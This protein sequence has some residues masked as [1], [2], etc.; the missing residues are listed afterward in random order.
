MRFSKMFIP[1]LREDP[2]EAEAISHKLLLRGGFI[3]RLA[4]GL[5]MYLPLGWRVMNKINQ[6]IREEM[7]AIGALEIN[8]P[9]LHP[10]EVWQQTGRW[11]DVGEEM[12]RLKDRTN[13]DL[14]LGMT[15][16]EIITFLVSKDVRSYRN[17]PLFLYQIQ[18]KFR[19][20]ARPRG[21]I[22]RT[23]E[24][25]MK[26]SYSFDKDE[27]GLSVSYDLH[28]E[29]Y[30]RI[31]NRCGLE[32][33]TAESDPGMMGGFTAHEFMSPTTEGE[34][35]IVL[36][37]ECG[38]VANVE[39]AAT[40]SPDVEASKWEFEEIF[41]KDNKTVDEVSNFLNLPPAYFIKSLLLIGEN[42]PFLA[43]IRGDQELHEKKLQRAIQGKFRPATKDEVLNILKVEAGNI[44]PMGHV[45]KRYADPSLQ[46]GSYVTGANK[47]NY[48]IRGVKANVHFDA[49]WHDIHI[50]KAG[51]R[52][53]KC[54]S[55]VRMQ[56]AVEIGNTFRLGTKYSSALRAVYLDDEGREKPII[57]GS[58]GIGPAR[59]AAA[60]V[61]Q[62]HDDKGI[63]WP[64]SIA[65]FDVI[66]L[67]LTKKDPALAK[68]AETL[69]KYLTKAGFEALIDDRD[70]RP[71]VKFNDADLIGI[72]WQVI[73]GTRSVTEGCVELKSR[74][75]GVI[76]KIK[77]E[78][79]VEKLSE[80]YDSPQIRGCV[81]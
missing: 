9:A 5:Y 58:Y 10:A 64:A 21:G 46:N 74:Q 28:L 2:S 37:D 49:E 6:I 29:A 44:G 40:F 50:S 14:C 26:D 25:I 54:D 57:M 69:T 71:G 45:L 16:E 72:P 53:S 27:E 67:P 8:L 43:L 22:I 13:R 17:L 24:F 23:R 3:R 41:T 12:F 51:D 62:N 66:L 56:H 63:I 11:S 7:N 4:T 48:H 18:T 52:C 79:V 55:S 60:A 32:F 15:H 76:E 20:E 61:Q 31:F 42:G 68:A 73:I 39:V 35:E 30:C 47:P 36:C 19:D 33:Y 70:E 80:K 38:Y 65:P 1:T 59:V 75:T 34:D 81:F 77:L 78:E